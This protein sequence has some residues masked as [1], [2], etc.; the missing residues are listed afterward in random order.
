ME[1]NQLKISWRPSP[2]HPKHWNLSLHVLVSS[3]SVQPHSLIITSPGHH[4][5]YVQCYFQFHILKLKKTLNVKA[6]NLKLTFF[7][8]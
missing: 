3:S 2:N 5:E 4:L 7:I 8:K 1:E 6:H